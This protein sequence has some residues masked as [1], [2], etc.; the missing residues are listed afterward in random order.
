MDM[1]EQGTRE[2]GGEFVK[3]PARLALARVSVVSLAMVLIIWGGI[4][5]G[6]LPPL[7][8]FFGMQIVLSL[9]IQK[10]FLFFFR[11]VAREAMLAF[12]ASMT[13]LV[14]YLSYFWTASI[15]EDN[16]TKNL[17]GSFAHGRLELNKWS[18]AKI[19]FKCDEALL[20]CLQISNIQICEY[21]V[22]WIIVPTSFN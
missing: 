8:M 14:R 18:P 1:G 3:R 2:D 10:L 6:Y 12:V 11:F 16:G 13:I 4:N 5:K 9:I 21:E 20:S 7:C 17:L 19:C 15:L 22:I